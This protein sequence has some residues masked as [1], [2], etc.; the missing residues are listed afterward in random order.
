MEGFITV[1]WANDVNSRGFG[2]QP[3]VKAQLLNIIHSTRTV[4]R[5]KSNS[6]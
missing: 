5:S 3:G 6:R 2:E 1:G 4:M